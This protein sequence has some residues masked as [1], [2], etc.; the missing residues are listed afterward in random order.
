M[1]PTQ[2]DRINAHIPDFLQ[3]IY[4][5]VWKLLLYKPPVGIVAVLG[6][7]RLV[8]SGRIFRLQ[9]ARKDRRPKDDPRQRAW[10]L[11]P[12]DELYIRYGGIQPVRRTLCLAGLQTLEHEPTLVPYL[13]QALQAELGRSRLQFLQE[14]VEPL[15]QVEQVLRDGRKLDFGNAA[16]SPAEVNVA[17]GLAAVTVQIRA[18]DVLLRLARD[19]LL[20][21][22]YR[23]RRSRDYWQARVASVSWFRKHRKEQ[24]QRLAFVTA[25]YQTEVERL[26][27]LSAILLE[28]PHDLESAC[29]LETL[30][31]SEARNTTKTTTIWSGLRELQWSQFSLRW[32]AEG[33]GKLSLRYMDADELNGTVALKCLLDQDEW[34]EQA[35]QWTF[36]AR[37]TLCDILHETLQGRVDE[38]D[39]DTYNEADFVQLQTEWCVQRYSPET[40]IHA[41]WSKMALYVHR[42]SSWRRTGEGMKVRLRDLGLGDLWGRLDV[43]GI[44]STLLAVAAA[45]KLHSQ[46]VPYWPMFHHESVVVWHKTI[47]ILRARV[48]QPLKGIYDDIMNKNKGMFSAFGLDIE[49][50]SLDNMLRDLGCGDG[51][52]ESRREGLKKATELYEDQLKSGLV[53]N[54]LKGRLVRLLLIQV[55]QLKVGLLTALDTIDVL[56]KGNRIHFQVLAAIP[57]VAIATYGT[58]FF[59]RSLYNIRSRDLRPVTAVHSEM[60]SILDHIEKIL[61][62]ADDNTVDDWIKGTPTAK[63]TTKVVLSDVSLGELVLS[64]HTYLMKLEYSSPPIPSRECDQIHESLQALLG[65]QLGLQRSDQGTRRQVAW[66]HHVQNKHKDLLERL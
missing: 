23:L 24:S 16:L 30:R 12:D 42:L 10:R 49:Q 2:L 54:L 53:L 66:L 48:W 33:R 65:T 56:M 58:R 52:E 60:T 39:D 3:G 46:L 13:L 26:G 38:Q 61:L 59:I 37:S 45:D 5:G 20:S 43:L 27:R 28:R 14:I 7:L 44:P 18:L 6:G 8:W 22:T 36:Q 4:Q 40:D 1:T 29:L 57:A 35:R 19:R 34:V 9:A 21:T 62:L 31:V 25:A 32:N 17:V 47:E 51:T 64:L 11:D 63:P 15:A 41:Q 55:Q 50:E